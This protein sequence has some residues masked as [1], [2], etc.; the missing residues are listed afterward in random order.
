MKDVYTVHD[1]L[2]AGYN[3]EPLQCVHCNSL[4]VEFD[5][6]IGDGYCQDCG[7]W[8]LSQADYERYPDIE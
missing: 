4:E 5:Q 1:V 3:L 8:Q 6:Y 7:Q 2:Q